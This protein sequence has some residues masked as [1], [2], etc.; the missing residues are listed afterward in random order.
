MHIGKLLKECIFR[1]P[2][3]AGG[4]MAD[5]QEVLEQLKD[6]HP[7]QVINNSVTIPLYCV[8][9]EY[10]TVRRN[11]RIG[12]KYF[13]GNVGGSDPYEQEVMAE[14]YLSRWVDN[15]NSGHPYRAIS[16]VEILEVVHLANAHL[17]LW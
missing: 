7:L 17:K 10:D 15:F 8:T 11:R 2:D 14:T 13:F 4:F 3:A 1:M 12:K 6:M 9:Y 5:G 16:N